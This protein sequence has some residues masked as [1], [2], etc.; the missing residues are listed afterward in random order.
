MTEENMAE[1]KR[2]LGILKK[3]HDFYEK[4]SFEEGTRILKACE[5]T[6]N[7]LNSRFN[8]DKTWLESCVIFGNDFVKAEKQN[9]IVRPIVDK[10]IISEQIKL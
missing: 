6:I 9:M 7:K 4:A 10:K 2:L 5:G 3:A 1:L 8:I